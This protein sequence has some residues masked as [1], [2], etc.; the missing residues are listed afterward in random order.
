MDSFDRDIVIFNPPLASRPASWAACCSCGWQGELRPTGLGALR[1]SR[2]HLR[3]AHRL[4]A[5]PMAQA[6]A[7]AASAPRT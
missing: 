4:Q 2:K 5:R 6:S 3:R 7:T 1:D